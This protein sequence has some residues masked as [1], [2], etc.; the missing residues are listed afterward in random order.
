MYLIPLSSVG[1]SLPLSRVLALIGGL[2]LVAAFFM[3]WFASQ[4]LLLSGQF[5]NDFLASATPADLQRFMPGTSPAQARLLRGL[6]DLF[7]VCGLAAALASLLLSATASAPRVRLPLR[8]ILLLSGSAP[9]VAWLV[10][11][12]QLPP[13]A[14]LQVGLWLIASAAL[15]IALGAALDFAAR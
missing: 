10:G 6:V 2:A 3:P 12:S 13:G 11:V 1:P 9:A 14:T 4:G 8:V 7:P 5:L 15:A